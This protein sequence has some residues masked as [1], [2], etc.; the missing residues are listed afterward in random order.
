MTGPADSA[1]AEASDLRTEAAARWE[2]LFTAMCDPALSAQDARTAG[3]ILKYVNHRTGAAWPSQR[4]LARHSGTT[5]RT[6]KRS[7][8]VLVER[9]YITVDN[10]DGKLN[11]YR[12]NYGMV[13]PTSPVTPMSPHRGHPC[14][15]TGDTYVPPPVTPVSP[16][17]QYKEQVEATQPD[18]LAAQRDCADGIIRAFH[19]G[20][21]KHFGQVKTARTP[22]DWQAAMGYAASGVR[23]EDMTALMD[24]IAPGMRNRS[25]PYVPATLRGIDRD[26]QALIAEKEAQARDAAERDRPPFDSWSDDLIRALVEQWLRRDWGQT[27]LWNDLKFGPAPGEPGCCVPEH[28][29]AEFNLSMAGPSGARRK[30]VAEARCVASGGGPD[31]YQSE[32]AE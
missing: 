15:L 28:I 32:A 4:T 16:Q 12:I 18:A 24:R 11:T 21:E 29:L 10:Q 19:V 7:I 22:T 13:T 25:R 20:L 17:N 27:L 23:P 30:R 3:L 2:W 9:G 6:I 5:T 31:P 8:R 26:V 14:P 1:R